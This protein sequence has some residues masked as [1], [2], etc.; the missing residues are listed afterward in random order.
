MIKRF[1]DAMLD[2]NPAFS[3]AILGIVIVCGCAMLGYAVMP[4]GSRVNGDTSRFQ[5]CEARCEALGMI[6]ESV[7]LTS[8][9]NGLTCRCDRMD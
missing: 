6:L 8:S 5:D 3:G 2:F 7:T 1:V 9:N 4:A